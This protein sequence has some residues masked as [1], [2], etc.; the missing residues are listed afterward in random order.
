MTHL[1][2]ATPEV[3]HMAGIQ[4]LFALRPET[5]APLQALAQQLLRGPSSLTPAERETIAALVS[6]DNDCTY[7][8]R[9]HEAAAC[10]LTG[11]RQIVERARELATSM[12][13]KMQALCA[14]AHKVARGGKNVG[15]DDVAAARAAGADDVAIHDTV[16]VAA[17]FCMFNRYVD[18]LAAPTPEPGPAY[19]MMGQRLAGQGYLR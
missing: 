1:T 6:F 19:A 12:T 17:A 15:V 2:T 5:A 7:C 14:I 11:D 16:L 13:P 18:G 10:A 3:A 9:S 8:A 4:Q